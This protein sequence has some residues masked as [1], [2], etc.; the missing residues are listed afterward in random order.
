MPAGSILV[1]DDDTAIRTV[2]NQ[3]LSRA[4]YEVRLTG[5]A[6]T[7]WRWVSQGEGDLVITDVVMPGGVTGRDLAD[8]LRLERPSLKVVFCSG[9]GADII[10]PE[11]MTVPNNRFL[12]K[13]FDIGRLAEVVRELLDAS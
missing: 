6:A 8:R 10:G 3:A 12:A 13:P 9:Y 4:G 2:L 1:A 5:N 11:I 7:L